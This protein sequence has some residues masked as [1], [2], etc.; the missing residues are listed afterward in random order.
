VFNHKA[1]TGRSGTF[2]GYEGLGSIYWHMVSKL[3]LAAQEC[4]IKAIEEKCDEKIVAGLLQH[5]QEIK[6]G[7]GVHKSPKL[8]G[9]FST[10]PYSHTPGFRGAQQPGMTG[11]VK[12]DVLVRRKE[13][14]VNVVDGKLHFKPTMLL[15]NDFLASP[16]TVAFTDI[17]GKSSSIQIPPQSL[18]FTC[19]QI[20][21]VYHLA[22]KAGI[23]VTHHDGSV[24]E[25]FADHL[26]EAA[27][28]KIFNR[29]GDI[30]Q[31]E[32]SLI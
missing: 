6:A 4:C 11:Q 27:S 16:K 25:I 13:L 14:G 20:P 23:S 28:Q 18:F 2:Y 32:V 9:A 26:D 17:H 15:K 5:Y 8:Y 1:F 7:I 31:I 30:R 21:V 29:T 19:C 10:D 24:T 3:L 22:D 12:E